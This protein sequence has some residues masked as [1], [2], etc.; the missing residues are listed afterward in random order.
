M[1]KDG[2]SNL[3]HTLNTKVTIYHNDKSQYQ[4]L[5][6]TRGFQSSVS[7]VL[8]FGL[9][10]IS[11][12]DSLKVV[13]PNQST[14]LIKNV[15]ANQR[16][17]LDQKNATGNYRSKKN[18]FAY[19]TSVNNQGVDFSHSENEYNDFAK[20]LLLPH[21]NSRFGPFMSMG[22]VNKDGLEVSL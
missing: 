6:L 13:W 4:E 21:Q 3:S 10:D 2:K 7:S 19:F 1:E 15:K 8:Q 14:Q 22:D 12:V 5:T 16:L 11:E 9:N 18:S 17:V 20:E